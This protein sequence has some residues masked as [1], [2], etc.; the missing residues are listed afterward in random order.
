M[1][2]FVI[3]IIESCSAAGFSQKLRSIFLL[4]EEVEVPTEQVYK[5]H[6]Q[7]TK[8]GSHQYRIAPVRT[9][10]A[11]IKVQTKVQCQKRSDEHGDDSRQLSGCGSRSC[12]VPAETVPPECG[13]NLPAQAIG[14]MQ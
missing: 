13:G 5:L 9:F 2:Q 4:C 12:P 10:D 1:F 7:K 11:G 6:G 8:N 3:L 14:W